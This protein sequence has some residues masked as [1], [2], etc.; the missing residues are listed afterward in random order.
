[1]NSRGGKRQG[2]GRP[3]S[4]T[5]RKV[6][7]TLLDETWDRIEETKQEQNISQSAVLR[8]IIEN[9]Y[10]TADQPVVNEREVMWWEIAR[11]NVF[12]GIIEIEKSL[13]HECILHRK[14]SNELEK[15][16]WDRCVANSRAYRKPRV[17]YLLDAFKFEG[18]RLS[19]DQNFESLKEQAIF[20]IIEYVR[21]NR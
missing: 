17:S 14:Y 12:E 4:G 18:K 2:A 21:L 10:T 11:K 6:S 20:S 7:L 5:T 13:L 16:V 8:S 19:F 1:M 15:E 9:H 3:A